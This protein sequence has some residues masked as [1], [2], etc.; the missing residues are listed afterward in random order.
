MPSLIR[1]IPIVLAILAMTLVMAVYGCFAAF[2]MGLRDVV[3][4]GGS[5]RAIIK[6][7]SAYLTEY[8][9]IDDT[10]D[11]NKNQEKNAGEKGQ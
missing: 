2:L 10:P 11:L 8:I 4:A 5:V 3:G 6:T 1:S 9:N 7:L